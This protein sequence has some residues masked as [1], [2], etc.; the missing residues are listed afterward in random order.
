MSQ[1]QC[2]LWDG[3]NKNKICFQELCCRSSMNWLKHAEDFLSCSWLSRMEAK[4][5]GKQQKVDRQCQKEWRIALATAKKKK[6]KASLSPW[7]WDRNGTKAPELITKLVYVQTHSMPSRACQCLQPSHFRPVA[8]G[9][10][11]QSPVTGSQGTGI[12]P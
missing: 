3:Q 7:K 10:H 9:R 1:R 11:V 2:Q 6:K 4:T 12:E 8:P 5:A